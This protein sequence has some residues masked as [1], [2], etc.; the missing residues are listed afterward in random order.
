MPFLDIYFLVF[1][2]KHAYWVT[3]ASD[4]SMNKV[5]IHSYL[6]GSETFKDFGIIQD[7]TAQWGMKNEQ[8]A[9]VWKF[10]IM[11][12]SNENIPQSNCYDSDFE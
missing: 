7:F 3:S 4:T 9:N 1:L 11:S 12:K 10:D 2:K 5:D 8:M 6:K